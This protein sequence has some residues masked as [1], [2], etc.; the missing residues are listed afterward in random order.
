[1][2]DQTTSAPA[3]SR[4]FWITVLCFVLAN[5]AIWVAYDRWWGSR[6][7]TVLK[8][9][10]FLPGDGSEVDPNAAF[11][12][13][14][15]TELSPLKKGAPAPAKFSPPLEGRWEIS[16]GQT[17]RFVPKQPLRGATAYMATLV[18]ESIRGRDGA[19]LSHP[20]T[21]TVHTAPLRLENVR[22]LAVDENDRI[23]LEF[24]FNDAVLP[25]DL[26]R[27]ASLRGPHGEPISFETAGSVAGT[28]LRVRTNTVTQL[29][30]Q[31]GK[32][33]EAILKKGICGTQGPLGLEA[34]QV[35]QVEIGVERVLT[36]AR[37]YSPSQGDPFITLSC[38]N[39][40]DLA[41]LR[42]VLSIEPTVAFTLERS[43]HDITV[44]GPFVPGTRYIVKVAKAPQDLAPN[45][46]RPKTIGVQI[47]DR[48]PGIWFE[49]QEGYLGSQ[50]NRTVL[51]H[52]VNYSHVRLRINR[53]YDSNLVEWRNADSRRSQNPIDYGQR[54]AIRDFRFSSEKNK[55]QAL[56]LSLDDLL[57]AGEFRDGVYELAMGAV[58][59]RIS[60]S[61]DATD[62]DEERLIDHTTALVTLS[63]I[64]LSAKS[65]RQGVTIW[66]ASLSSAKPIQGVRARV[67]SNKNQLL[68]Q[69]ITDA[70]GL[71]QLKIT[72]A[73][74]ENPTVIVAD[75]PASEVENGSSDAR[76][77]WRLAE[78]DLARPAKRSD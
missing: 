68:G 46:P 54:V 48:D 51:A 2:A 62:D 27:F 31:N 43:Y 41:A 30:D 40:I 1:M 75:Q 19:L 55:E 42:Q 12:W 16:D 36:E 9:K 53:V 73:S 47:P 70:D 21:A 33:V 71:G 5:S 35:R 26:N 23:L 28:T 67:Y 56:R 7:T 77:G 63:D 72:P 18:P 14:F 6:S 17:L 69:V 64:G 13:A 20:F 61:S 3:G 22:Q 34:D 60:R 10:Q 24:A 57:P 66:A 58:D 29:L 76:T 8:V 38:N 49:H 52:V 15:N 37:G 39:P 25:A 50:G 45:V 32:F 11:T 44:H 65:G 78:F 4:R 59:P 74:G